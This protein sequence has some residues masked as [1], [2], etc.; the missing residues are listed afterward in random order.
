MSSIIFIDLVLFLS[1]SHFICF[2]LLFPSETGDE[3]G[4]EFWPED[5]TLNCDDPIANMFLTFS[6]EGTPLTASDYI[7][8]IVSSQADNIL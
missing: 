2:F 5:A 4:Y 6:Y 7:A 8:S 1:N 3:T